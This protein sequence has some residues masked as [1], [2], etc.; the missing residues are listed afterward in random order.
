MVS[1]HLQNKSRIGAIPPVRGKN[2]Q[3][4]QPTPRFV[5]IC[6]LE[7]STLGAWCVLPG[8]S[9]MYWSMPQNCWNW[10]QPWNRPA[11][12]EQEVAQEFRK[13]TIDVA[14]HRLGHSRELAASYWMTADFTE[15]EMVLAEI[16]SP[17]FFSTPNC[18]SESTWNSQIQITNRNDLP[19]VP[20][21]GF[22]PFQT[23]EDHTYNRYPNDAWC[24]I[25]WCYLSNIYNVN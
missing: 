5:C 1:T 6:A 25:M 16:S 12:P 13:E 7:W 21:L 24:H 23:L 15:T 19:Q 3:Y 9:N 11:C 17:I 10:K 8:L 22:K 4:L 20:H 2:K 14:G 18:A